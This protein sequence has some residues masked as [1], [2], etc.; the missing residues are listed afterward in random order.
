MVSDVSDE[1]EIIVARHQP[2][3][4]RG[5]APTSGTSFEAGQPTF[6]AHKRSAGQCVL[7]G[8]LFSHPTSSPC[9]CAVRLES[10]GRQRR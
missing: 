3:H 8:A 7:T 9:C 2:D 5:P 1:P 6:V 4:Q 10:A